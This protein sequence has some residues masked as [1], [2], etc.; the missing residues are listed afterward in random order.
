M[1]DKKLPIYETFHT[2]QGEGQFTGCNAFFMRTY[3]C[4]LHCPWCDSAGTWHKDYRPASV[5]R[6]TVMELTSEVVRSGAKIAVITGG[7][8]TIHDLDPLTGMLIEYGISPH[9]ET[10]GAFPIKGTFNWITLSPK[11]AKLPLVENVV[12]ASELKL[13][14]ESKE[15]AKEWGNWLG[16]ISHCIGNS[17]I[18]LHPEW[19]K[20]NDPEVLEIITNIIKNGMGL[21]SSLNRIEFR[22]GYQMHKLYRADSFDPKASS[23]QIP[24]GGD[25][26]LGNSQ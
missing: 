24:L 26:T 14:I 5:D 20:R 13:I 9:L 15:S 2:F 11:W 4:P 8:P 16:S 1:K 17:P 19:S 3:G 22:A 6:K 7:E 12:G 18:Y 10:S 23:A 21:P 25:V